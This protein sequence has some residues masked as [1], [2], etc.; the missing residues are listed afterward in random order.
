[1][2]ITDDV[3]AYAAERGYA[4]DDT[5]KVLEEQ[6]FER[7]SWTILSSPWAH[8]LSLDSYA[9][10]RRHVRAISNW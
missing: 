6:N 3:R 9:A 7:T 10:M 4:E 5:E 1:M 8:F 2:K